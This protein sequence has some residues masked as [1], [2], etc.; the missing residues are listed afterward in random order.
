MGVGVGVNIFKG[1]LCV[2]I[3]TIQPSECVHDVVMY[4]HI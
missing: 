4:M 1:S 2:C 3:W